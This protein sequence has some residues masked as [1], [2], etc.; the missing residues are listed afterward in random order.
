MLQPFGLLVVHLAAFVSSALLVRLFWRLSGSTR[1]SLWG[2]P[3]QQQP[4]PLQESY[5]CRE[6]KVT[7]TALTIHLDPAIQELERKRRLFWSGT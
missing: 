7:P 2:T 3:Q 1:P 5:R 6:A 4:V